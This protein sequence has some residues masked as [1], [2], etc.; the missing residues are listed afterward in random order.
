MKDAVKRLL[1]AAADLYKRYPARA[2][3]LVIAG[4]VAGLGALGVTVDTASVKDVV[5]TVLPILIGGEVIH[6][7][8]SPAR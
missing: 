2:T 1:N 6:R 8:V 7:Q 5:A 4:V 3:S